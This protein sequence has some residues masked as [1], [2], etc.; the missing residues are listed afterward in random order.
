MDFEQLPIGQAEFLEGHL[1]FV[2]QPAPE[3]VR[4]RLRRL[5]D[6]LRH[7]VREATLLGLADIPL[8]L[9][10]FRLDGDAADRAHLRPQL[11]DRHHLAF[12]QQQDLLRVRD[13]G[14]DIGGDEPLLDADADDQWGIEPGTD[15]EIRIALGEDRHRIGAPEL[16]QRFPHGRHQVALVVLLDQ[17]G[18]DLG[19]GLGDEDM[20]ARLQVPAQ[21]GKVLDDPVVDHHDL[22]VAVGV[23]VGVDDGRAAMGRPAGVADAEPTLG[24]LLGQALDQGVDLGG[25]LHHGGLAV[26]LVEDRDPGGVIAAVF[27]PLEAVHDDGRR[28]ALTQIPDDPAHAASYVPTPGAIKRANSVRSFG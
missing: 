14:G 10:H 12:T 1:A 9:D 17:V 25:A 20:A 21:L 18:D 6:L 8:D 23:R 22:L 24:H 2:A 4:D 28:R 19:V 16:R 26:R 7:E 13:H 3:C 27:Q 11:A 15:Q 5:V